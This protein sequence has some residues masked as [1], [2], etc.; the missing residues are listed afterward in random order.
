MPLAQKMEEPRVNRSLFSAAAALSARQRLG[1]SHQQVAQ[2][3]NVFHASIHPDSLVAWENGSA[4]PT[5]EQLFAL[6]DVLWCRTV[7]LM[8]IDKPRT[9]AELRLTR[10]FT[11][12]RLAKAIGMGA[13]EYKEAEK[14]NRWRGNG[15]QTLDL[16]NTLNI[17]MDQLLDITDQPKVQATGSSFKLRTSLWTRIWPGQTAE[18]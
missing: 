3:M 4:Q 7:D 12:I 8:D 6:A 11:V 16:L 9:L 2:Q 1:M 10:Q 14:Q 18:L 13:A 5:E 17:S 15:Q